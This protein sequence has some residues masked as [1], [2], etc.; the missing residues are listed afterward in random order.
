LL[1]CKVND[2]KEEKVMTWSRTFVVVVALVSSTPSWAEEGG[3]W[4][5]K[6]VLVNTQITT[7]QVADQEDHMLM[8]GDDRGLVF[9][10]DGKAFLDKAEYRVQW[11]VDTSGTVGGG[12]KTFTAPDGQIFA[13][14]TI[15]ESTDAGGAG[16]WEF[17]GGTGRYQGV[18][19]SG[20][21]NVTNVSETVYWDMLEGE[22][23]IP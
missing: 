7:S 8:L 1:D 9:N 12:Y 18:S 11:M 10:E 19:G 16:T 13:K 5:G 23:K 3:Q 2:S 14:F 6:A 20:T 22:Y 4:R 17:T 21:F 15:T